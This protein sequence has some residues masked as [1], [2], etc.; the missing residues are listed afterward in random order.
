MKNTF[1]IIFVFCSLYGFSQSEIINSD[2]CWPVGIAEKDD[3]LYIA[4]GDCDQITTIDL[5]D[6]NLT[7]ETFLSFSSRPIFLD[8]SMVA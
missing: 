3:I 5:N 8:I 2:A 4:E 6:P 7:K 1:L